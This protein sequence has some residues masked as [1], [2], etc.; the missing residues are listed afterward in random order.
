MLI[1]EPSWTVLEPFMSG[2][3]RGGRAIFAIPSNGFERFSKLQASLIKSLW[4]V[5][6]GPLG[7]HLGTFLGAMLEPSWGQD[8]GILNVDFDIEFRP[9]LGAILGPTWAQL[10]TQ[11]APKPRA[12]FSQG[13]S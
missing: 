8:G 7:A 12:Q 2:S 13:V 6:R 1:F 9:L 5:F 4:S 10:G 3:W 11:E